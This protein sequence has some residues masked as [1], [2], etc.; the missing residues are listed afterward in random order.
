MK[1][2]G[3]PLVFFA[4]L[5][6]ALL[7]ARSQEKGPTVKVE[8]GPNVRASDKGV[9]HVEPHIAAHPADPKNLIIAASHNVEGKGVIAEAFFTTD[10]GKTWVVSPMPQMR[11]ALLANKVTS[12]VDVWITYGM[13]RLTSPPSPILKFENETQTKYWSI[14]LRIEAR[15]GRAR[16]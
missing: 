2:Y 1:H 15:P 14:V 9:S 7:E 10:A 5:A 11:E 3:I 12:A 6:I 13:A 4:L 16:L 8:I